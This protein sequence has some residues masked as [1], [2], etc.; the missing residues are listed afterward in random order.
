MSV[1]AYYWPDQAFV[2]LLFEV[3]ANGTDYE[4]LE[5]TGEDKGGDWT[6][7]VYSADAIPEGT[8]HLKIT[9]Q[10]T[11]GKSWTPQLSRVE[12]GYLE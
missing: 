6:H 12:L 8:T 5:V 3:S 7:W 1:E 9:I 2:D 4:A 10:D 11:S